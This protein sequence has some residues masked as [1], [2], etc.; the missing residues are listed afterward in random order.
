MRKAGLKTT[1][2]RSIVP[3]RKTP[4]NCSLQVMCYPPEEGWDMSTWDATTSAMAEAADG[5][6][7]AFVNTLAEA[8]PGIVR[9]R[10][11]VS[12]MAALL[13]L[14][15]DLRAVSHAARYGERR[16][17]LNPEAMLLADSTAGDIDIETYTLDEARTKQRLAAAGLGI[18]HQ[19]VISVA[20]PLPEIPCRAALK[21]IVP[22][23][24]HKAEVGAVALNLASEE[25]PGAVQ[26][27]S[28]RL[29]AH[30]LKADCFLIDE[31]INVP[32]DELLVGIRRVSGVGAVLTLAIGGGCRGTTG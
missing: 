21:A 31:M 28:P 3:L 32:V 14:E 10:M 25:L 8:L 2:C 17:S 22:G 18:P 27:M 26:Q 1:N 23:L 29:D 11:N 12:G 30:Q 5:R 16:A 4:T 15:D 7:V 9:D 19:W 20:D 6:P 24:L 13:G